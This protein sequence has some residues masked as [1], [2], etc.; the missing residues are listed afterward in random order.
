MNIPQSG[1]NEQ[2]TRFFNEIAMAFQFLAIY[3][4]LAEK[5][6]LELMQYITKLQGSN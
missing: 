5:D 4:T 2:K 3:Y 1:P 6:Q